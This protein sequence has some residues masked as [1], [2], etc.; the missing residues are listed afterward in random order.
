MA[1]P[2]EGAT[3]GEKAL[4]EIQKILR[5]F[6]C[7]KFGSLTDDE[8]RS[9]TV[10]FEFQGRMVSIRASM[11]G[12][13]AAWLKEHPF[14]ASRHRMSLKQYERKA[15]DIASIAVYSIL[16]DWI[17]GQVTAIETGLLEFEGVFLGQILLGNGNTVHEEVRERNLLPPSKQLEAPR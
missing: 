15:L 12:Y 3:S 1:L 11:R 2:Y 9:I 13:A 17:K 14:N 7:S 16:R 5:G 10:Q 8:D 6:G 4:G